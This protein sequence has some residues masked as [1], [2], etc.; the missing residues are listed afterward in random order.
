MNVSEGNT[1]AEIGRESHLKVLRAH[2]RHICDTQNEADGV[3]DVGLSAAIE[4]SDGVEALVPA[5]V[6][7]RISVAVFIAWALFTILK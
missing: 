1:F 5:S 7:D 6:S 2:C 4:T 3:Q